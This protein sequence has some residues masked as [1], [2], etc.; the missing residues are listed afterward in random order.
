[1]RGKV[2]ARSALWMRRALSSGAHADEDTRR[3]LIMMLR[4]LFRS[5][6]QIVDNLA[7]TDNALDDL[8]E[9][10]IAAKAISDAEE[11]AEEGNE[12]SVQ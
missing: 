4:E 9:R 7:E 5:A 12:G 3:T 6:R 10:L 1:M 8:V 11:A 2:F